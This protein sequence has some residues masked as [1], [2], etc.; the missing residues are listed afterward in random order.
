MATHKRACQRRLVLVGVWLVGVLLRASITFLRWRLVH[1]ALRPLTPE[2][3]EDAPPHRGRDIAK[4][5]VEVG[6]CPRQRRS[7]GP[8]VIGVFRRR[9]ILPSVM[10]KTQSPESMEPI[11]AH[12]LVHLQRG[13]TFVSLLQTAIQIVWWFH[14]LVGWASREVSLQ[15]ERCADNEVLKLGLLHESTPTVCCPV[16]E[17][18]CRV[19]ATAAAVGM[20]AM[21][22]TERR[23]GKYHDRTDA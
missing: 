12:E 1:K 23:L 11:V 7:L 18:K 5:G 9:L 13:D 3:S 6:G 10:L 20:N 15:N 4:I 17:T 14:P 19:P 8:A 21:Q 16:L 2:G 22:I